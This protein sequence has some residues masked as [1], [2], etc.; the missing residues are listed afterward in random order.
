MSATGFQPRSAALLEVRGLQKT[1]TSKKMFARSHEVCAARDVSFRLS[2]GEA[3]ALVGES[4]SGKSTIARM[5]LRLEAPDGGEIRLAGQDVLASEPGRASL[6]Y[7]GRVQM[8][9][10]DPFGS[11]NP[12][13]SVG[14]HLERPLLRHGS[15]GHQAPAGAPGALRSLNPAQDVSRHLKRPL[16][17]HGVPASQPG[18]PDRRGGIPRSEI[19]AR[20]LELLR[21]VGLDPPEEF[22]GRY[23][24]EL[25]GGQ[26]QRVAIARAL[27]V[28]PDLL[29]ADEPTSMLDV[30]IRMGVLNI[31]SSLKR[32][33][34][35]AI[36]L[37]THDLASARYLA[38]RIL[39]LYRG[40]LVEDGPSEEI[41]ASPKHPYTRALLASIADADRP[42]AG[43][44]AVR[45][46]QGGQEGAGCP[47]AARCLDRLDVCAQ[48]DPEPR[49]LGNRSVRCHLYP[50][51]QPALPAPQA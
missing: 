20:V 1:F 25:S 32:D 36:L 15:P 18:S 13:H 44:A 33:H 28:S 43:G 38:D 14:H 6:A 39:V 31:L 8:V 35:L 48:S 10:Q 7:R 47:F 34:G 50:A 24:H 45:T 19:H 41:V 37:I 2:H 16:E 42:V 51:G 9:F 22:V 49:M 4:G 3:V 5:L 11:L 26:R 29:V 27:A 21:T 30:S 23:P 40:R 17:R 12:V 46:A